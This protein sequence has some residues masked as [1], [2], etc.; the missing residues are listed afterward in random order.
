MIQKCPK[1][2]MWCKAFETDA[3]ERAIMEGLAF[4]AKNSETGKKI[5]GKPGEVLG[6]IL[7]T[8]G[9]VL[10]AGYEALLG[11]RYKFVC[12]NCE[13]RWSTDSEFDDESENLQN[14]VLDLITEV[15]QYKDSTQNEKENY[16]SS[17]NAEQNKLDKRIDKK[18]NAYIYAGLAYSYFYLANDTA[19]AKYN[20]D[21]AL[22]LLPNNASM[23]ALKG[24]VSIEERTALD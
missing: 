7:G 6:G 2:G 22:E 24:I 17:L 13:H 10:K 4:I 20:I 11:D 8:G 15:H 14:E 16:I 18:F 3:A 21:Q 5:L 19:K 9:G 1:C 12:P 23:I